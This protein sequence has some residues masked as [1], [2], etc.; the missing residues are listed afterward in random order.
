MQLEFKIDPNTLGMNGWDIRIIRKNVQMRND[1][2]DHIKQRELS[3]P[4]KRG[5]GGAHDKAEFDRALADEGGGVVDRTP[6]QAYRASRK[7]SISCRPLMHKAT[8]PAI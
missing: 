4:R 8:L 1:I 7:S 2:A 5:I 6:I 3:V